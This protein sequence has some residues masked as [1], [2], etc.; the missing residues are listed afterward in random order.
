MP[1][2]MALGGA[3]SVIQGSFYFLGNRLDS[4]KDEDDEFEH[5][6]ILRR[7]TRLPVGQSVAELGESRGIIAHITS[8]EV[9][10]ADP[11]R[12]PTSWV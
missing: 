10:I 12:Y 3:C 5:K 6:E 2:V 9:S 4:F 1:I 8:V 11:A 7:T